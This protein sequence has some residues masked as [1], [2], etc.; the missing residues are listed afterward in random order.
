MSV[1]AYQF[2]SATCAPCKVI[3]PA[4]QD[5]RDEFLEINWFHIDIKNDPDEFAKKYNVSIVPTLVVELRDS[6]GNSLSVEKHSGTSIAGY[7][8]IVRNAL[9]SIQQS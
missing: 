1:R 7:Y 3:K 9:R 6:L 8:R 4:L 5:L 2:S